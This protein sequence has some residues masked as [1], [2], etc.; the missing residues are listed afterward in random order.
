MKINFK[1]SENEH[2]ELVRNNFANPV[3]KY[4]IGNDLLT[5]ILFFKPLPVLVW[6]MKI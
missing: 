2:Y 4:F 3:Q 6:T 5:D 1:I